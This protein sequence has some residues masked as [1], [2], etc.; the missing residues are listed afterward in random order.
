MCVWT[1]ADSPEVAF[2]S[3]IMSHNQELT[4]IR[5]ADATLVSLLYV[6]YSGV[7]LI[8]TSSSAHT[9][10]SFLACTQRAQEDAREGRKHELQAA[11]LEWRQNAGV[12]SGSAHDLKR[13]SASDQLTVELLL[14]EEVDLRKRLIDFAAESAN[15]TGVR[16]AE[17]KKAQREAAAVE[18]EVTAGGSQVDNLR[19]R[20]RALE[21]ELKKLEVTH[22][23]ARQQ[24]FLFNPLFSS[25]NCAVQADKERL[26]AALAA[27]KARHAEL[28]R[29]L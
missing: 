19:Q 12:H 9:H 25:F 15:Q 17:V 29:K 7:W 27:R 23:L 13:Q 11:A 21:Q 28:S 1:A 26:K 4:H 18:A 6:H 5:V 8:F 14:S 2:A 22:P 3:T 10:F 16:Q 24:Y 20:N